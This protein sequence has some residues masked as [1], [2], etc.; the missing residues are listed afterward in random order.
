MGCGVVVGGVV[1][2]GT[3]CASGVGES[4]GVVV[5]LGVGRSAQANA[6]MAVAAAA[7][8]KDI[9]GSRFIE[10]ALCG[11]G[12]TNDTETRC[13]SKR[14]VPFRLSWCGRHYGWGGGFPM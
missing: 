4:A 2:V 6:A 7:Q 11:S 1:A 9:V 13:E 10:Y 5:V 14:L 8:S 12:T 3:A